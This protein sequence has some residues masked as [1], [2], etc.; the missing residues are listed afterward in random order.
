MW[1]VIRFLHANNVH[2]AETHRQIVTLCGEGIMNKANV[3]NLCCSMKAGLMYMTRNKMCT[4]LCPQMIR[5]KE[6]MQRFRKTGN[7]QLMNYTDIYL[8]GKSLT[9]DQ[10][11]K[12]VV[13]DW[14]KGVLFRHFICTLYL[15]FNTVFYIVLNFVTFSHSGNS[16]ELYWKA[17]LKFLS[18]WMGP[19]Y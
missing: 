17:Y 11:T 1:S 4:H 13:Q 10:E 12:D 16:T 18:L 19:S 5:K 2:S 6:W 14:L 9:T 7:S 15:C 8:A 3:K